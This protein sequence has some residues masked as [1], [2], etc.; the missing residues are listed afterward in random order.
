MPRVRANSG[1]DASR[2]TVAACYEKIGKLTSAWVLFHESADLARDA[3]DTIRQEFALK[4]ISALIP[5]LPRLTIAGPTKPPPGFAVTRDGASLGLD[6]LGTELY[7]DPG[8]HEVTASAP[9]FDPF[10]VTLTVSEGQYE[11]VVIR[12]L[13]PTKPP[14]AEPQQ[15]R[16]EQPIGG[17]DPGRRRK[18][19]GLGLAGGGVVLTGLGFLFGAQAISTYHGVESLCGASL[20]CDNNTGF[21]R[22]KTLIDRARTQA[23]FSTALVITGGPPPPRAPSCG[24]LHSGANASRRFSFRS[25]PV[26]T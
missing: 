23:T 13:T 9:G 8:S 11:S 26:A 19:L 12:E 4:Q 5:R 6:T 24:S 3:G 14:V 16:P 1:V 21:E 22:G 2:P 20:I 18:L 15:P 25:Q 10:T 17:T 7:V